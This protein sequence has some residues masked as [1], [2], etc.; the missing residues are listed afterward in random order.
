MIAKRIVP[1]LDVKDGTVVKGVGFGNLRYAGDPVVLAQKYYEDGA[2][3]I[4]FLDISATCEN[5]DIMI[6][7]VRRTANDMFIPFTVGGGIRD[8]SD[9]R[10]I[11]ANGADKVALNT[12]GF[13]DPRLIS[14]VS[15]EFGAQCVVIAVDAKWNGAFYE[16]FI[17]G[18]RTGTGMD[19][20][21]WVKKCVELG[22]GEIL[23]TSIDRDGTKSGFDVELISLVSKCVNVPI[24]ASGGAREPVD[25]YDAFRVGADAALAASLF[26]YGNYSVGEVKEFLKRKGVVVRL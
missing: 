21:S 16:V 20:F 12:N 1:C 11:L 5:R 4:V 22:A 7:V 15:L 26:H 10:N 14:S 9:V 13:L 3:E 23:L 6:D 17:Y 19:V 8:V 25:F 2:D 24:I 18:G